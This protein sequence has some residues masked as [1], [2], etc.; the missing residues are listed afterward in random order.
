MAAGPHPLSLAGRLTVGRWGSGSSGVVLLPAVAAGGPHTVFSWVPGGGFRMGSQHHDLV[1]NWPGAGWDAER[2][3]CWGSR[4]IVW[5]SSS[6]NHPKFLDV[7]CNN[8][9]LQNGD[10]K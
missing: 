4:G 9:L 7:L 5:R 1:T 3:P 8:H 6:G 2:G 10:F